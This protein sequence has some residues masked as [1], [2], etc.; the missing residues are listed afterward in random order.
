MFQRRDDDCLIFVSK[1]SGLDKLIALGR[2]D[3][4][5]SIG[6]QPVEDC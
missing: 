1:Q 6:P 2:L 5:S 4:S 3:P